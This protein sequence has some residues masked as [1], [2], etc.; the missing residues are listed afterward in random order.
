MDRESVESVR[1]E[2]EEKVYPVC[3]M[4]SRDASVVQNA[5]NKHVNYIID[6]SESCTEF[7]QN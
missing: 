4:T 1:Y 7:E 6:G 3:C 5:N 2:G